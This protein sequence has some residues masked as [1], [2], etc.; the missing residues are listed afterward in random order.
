MKLTQRIV[1]LLLL[2]TPV[3]TG[4]TLLVRQNVFTDGRV[5]RG[6]FKKLGE[7]RVEGPIVESESIV[8]QLQLLHEDRSVAGVL[9]RI[10]SPG[11]ATAPSQEI[12]HAVR[13]FRS[14]SKPIIVS[15]GNVAASGGY[16]IA[17]PATRI[18]A[19][20]GTLTGSIGV[21]MTVPMYRELAKKVGI[22]MQTFKAG[23]YKDIASPYRS[24]TSV[25]KKMIQ[26]LL[27]DTHDQFITDVATARTMDVD[28]L[29]QI[30]DG[31]IFT[32]RQAVKAHLV[33]T[34][35][36]Y[37]AALSYLRAITGVGSAARVIN[38]RESSLKMR[39]WLVEESVRLFPH[40]YR[41]LSPIG[42]HCLAVFE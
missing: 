19:G 26:G 40:L 18:F 27:D 29:R 35:G 31:R 38:K 23:D 21:I 33:D 15:M 17:S 13:E 9:L 3:I 16:Y 22:E 8:R 7:V 28:S 41:I 20:A 30:A 36:G 4:V 10:D 24:M 5:G 34:L 1:L 42:M 12:Y 14:G 2:S 39:D 32:G 25:E 37:E 11:G 6:T